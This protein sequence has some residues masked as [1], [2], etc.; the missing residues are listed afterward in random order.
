M[1]TLKNKQQGKPF[2]FAHQ[3]MKD[4]SSSSRDRHHLIDLKNPNSLRSLLYVSCVVLLTISLYVYYKRKEKKIREK[5]EKPRDIIEG[6]Y[7][8][9]G[10]SR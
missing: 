1:I 3:Q 10:Y 4:S 8:M 9:V 5:L 2:P 6:R 7:R